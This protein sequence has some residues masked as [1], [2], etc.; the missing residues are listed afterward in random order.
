MGPGITAPV[1]GRVAVFEALIEAWDGE[2]VAIRYDRELATWMFIAV[3]STRLGPA[4]GGTRMKVYPS[5][6]DGLR[7]ALRLSSAMTRKL[8]VP[9]APY[10]GGK[11]VLAVP[12][13]PEGEAR[14]RLMERYGDF[15]DSLGGTYQTA[16]DVNTGSEDMDI[17]GTRTKHV[18]GRSPEA[19]GSG[20]TAPATA[21]GVYYGIRAAVE[22]ALGSDNLAGRTIVVQGVGDVGGRLAKL[23]AADGAKVLVSDIDERLAGTVAVEI[24]GAVVP[25]A[26]ALV[27]EC[28]VLAPC[29]LGGVLN[30]ESIP[31]LKCRV[32][33]G[34]ANN[35]LL[36]DSDA[37]LLKARGILYAPDY[38]VNAGGVLHGVGLE[39]LGWS[40]AELEEQ[41]KGITET[42]R[43]IFHA[44]ETEDLTTE[45]AA[46]RIAE[47]N[48][49]TAGKPR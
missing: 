24:G 3:H 42:L 9:C 27:T 32:V 15:V 11:A 40:E 48:I 25:V 44:A 16:P 41:L 36:R 12:R 43:E 13:V 14:V 46:Q 10:G 39:Q 35:Q 34:A 4:A 19:G 38:V 26:D 20:N 5:P 7:D 21:Q 18:F 8:A 29:A 47:R 45:L 22:H 1:E 31:R 49:E 6:S 30:P 33:A 28:D 37:Q 17:V 2:Q 23:L